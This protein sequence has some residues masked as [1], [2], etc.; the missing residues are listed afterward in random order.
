[1]SKVL[2]NFAEHTNLRRSNLTEAEYSFIKPLVDSAYILRSLKKQKLS[3]NF[4]FEGL[5]DRTVLSNVHKLLLQMLEGSREQD[6]ARDNEKL[7]DFYEAKTK[8]FDYANQYYELTT[9]TEFAFDKMKD[10]DREHQII[11]QFKKI[12]RLRDLE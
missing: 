10:M 9:P 6:E 8:M 11:S 5:L 1:M 7:A 3:E 2:T 4:V 12:E